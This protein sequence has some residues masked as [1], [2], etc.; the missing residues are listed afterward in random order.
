VTPPRSISVASADV[1]SFGDSLTG[2]FLEALFAA[3]DE[4]AVRYVVLRNYEQ[5]P[6]HFGKDVDLVVAKADLQRSHEIVQRVAR[7]LG[8]VW[9]LRRKRSSH[10]TYYLLP[11]PVDGVEPGILLDIRPNLVHRG[12]VYLPGALVLEGRRRHGAFFVPAP[13]LESLAILLHCLVDV[14]RVRD[15]YRERLRA[16]APSARDGFVEAAAAVVG[17]AL[18]RALAAG[19][20]EDGDPNWLVPLRRRLLLARALR[21]PAAPLRLLGTRAG[22]VLDRVRAF[23]RPPGRLVILVGPDGSGK[24][25]LSEE[26]SRRFAPTRISASAVYLGAQKPLLPTRRL[27]QRLRRQRRGASAARPIKDVNRR[28]RLRGLVHIMADKWARY[29][30]YVRPR[31]VRGEVVVLDRYFYD[32]RTFHHP[33]VLRP[34]V[35]ALLMRLIPEPAVAF[36]L[37]ADPAVIAIR[38]NELTVAETARQLERFRGIQRWVRN[39]HEIPADGHLPTVI[40]TIT[41]EVVRAWAEGRTPERA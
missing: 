17:P 9:T 6:E 16:L 10:R 30:V 4:E 31:L 3:Y 19:L 29:L 20:I 13:A 38:K 7:A 2:R 21:E 26:T 1:A 27:S 15:S 12:L 22:A 35:D 5:W 25:T 41:T 32:L 18:A 11:T 23:L 39:Y 36:C 40:D 14:G 28:L 34:W 8:L 33:F 24:T 37:R